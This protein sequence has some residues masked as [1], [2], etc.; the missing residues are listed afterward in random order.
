MVVVVARDVNVMHV[1]LTFP[2]SN[3]S[4]SSFGSS[5]SKVLTRMR[6][7][8]S[9]RTASTH[10]QCWSACGTGNLEEGLITRIAC[11]KIRIACK[12]RQKQCWSA[13][14]TGNLEEGLITRIACQKIRIACKSRQHQHGRKRAL[15]TCESQMVPVST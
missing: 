7:T 13:C 2:G 15:I 12:S 8:S 11:Q 9:T 5:S 6:L 1:H 4:K 10:K 3:F 14:G